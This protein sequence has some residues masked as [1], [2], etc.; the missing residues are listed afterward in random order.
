MRSRASREACS[1]EMV[2]SI[3]TEPGLL[4]L[5]W[6]V[7]FLKLEELALLTEGILGQKRGQKP[8][9]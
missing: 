7:L 6:T 8:R 5:L 3:Y 4:K 2:D 9:A 1:Q